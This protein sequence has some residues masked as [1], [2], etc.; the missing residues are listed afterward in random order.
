[1]RRVERNESGS[2][3]VYKAAAA[4]ALPFQLR[5]ALVI[6]TCQAAPR[7]IAG[8]ARR[9]GPGPLLRAER[10]GAGGMRQNAAPAP[11]ASRRFHPASP[12]RSA[13]QPL[14]LGI[15]FLLPIFTTPISEKGLFLDLI[16]PW[17]IKQSS[18]FI[19]G[20]YFSSYFSP[21]ISPFPYDRPGSEGRA[22]DAA[23]FGAL[24]R[25]LSRSPPAVPDLRNP[26]GGALARLADADGWGKRG[27]AGGSRSPRPPPF[28]PLPR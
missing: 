12:Q 25:R 17:A 11:P 22:E 20:F 23:M 4:E 1:M 26:R 6:G 10:G 2:G 5:T 28:L 15:S 9:G 7:I 3:R 24:C 18:V 16:Q 8:T 13:L 19:A 14:P 21:P 27:A